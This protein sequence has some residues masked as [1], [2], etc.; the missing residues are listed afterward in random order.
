MIELIVLASI[1]G[2]VWGGIGLY[3]LSK[4]VKRHFSNNEQID[5]DFYVSNSRSEL[6]NS[7]IYNSRFP[8][9]LYNESLP[10]YEQVESPPEYTSHIT[11]HVNLLDPPPTYIY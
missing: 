10:K 2:A 4:R 6:Y 1:Q 5:A 11:S 3:K 7:Q 9:A 8:R